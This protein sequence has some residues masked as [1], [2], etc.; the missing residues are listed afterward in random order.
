LTTGPWL[1]LVVAAGK[2]VVNEWLVPNPLSPP[3]T[4]V[5]ACLAVA[6]FAWWSPARRFGTTTVVRHL[7][8]LS[9]SLYLVHWPLVVT[10]TLLLGLETSPLVLLLACTLVSLLVADLLPPRR[11]GPPATGSPRPSDA[12]SPPGGRR[13]RPPDVGAAP[14]VM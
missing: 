9:F 8:R 12:G 7:G 14:A 13:A 2:F 3:L 1:L 4:L 6:A 10:V 11:R 5:G